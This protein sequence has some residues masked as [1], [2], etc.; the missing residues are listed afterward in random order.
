M[1]GHLPLETCLVSGVACL[2]RALLD[3]LGC[4]ISGWE[5]RSALE[6]QLTAWPLDERCEESD[7]SFI[8]VWFNLMKGWSSQIGVPGHQ[9]PWRVGG[10]AQWDP[11]EGLVQPRV[12]TGEPT[13]VSKFQRNWGLGGCKK[14][15]RAHTGVGEPKRGQ[16]LGSCLR[17][18]PPRPVALRT[19]RMSHGKV[20]AVK[21]CSWRE[22]TKARKNK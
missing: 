5:R 16:G 12:I 2:G 15:L 22:T 13:S 3:P 14:T 20:R 17:G 10:R 18:L 4:S 21:V 19:C 6:S 9:E 11:R 7:L 8:P 1:K